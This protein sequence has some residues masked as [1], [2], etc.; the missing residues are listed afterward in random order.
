MNSTMSRPSF[1]GRD[2]GIVD[3]GPYLG[4][5]AQPLLPSTVEEPNR[6]IPRGTRLRDAGTFLAAISVLL[7]SSAL[8]ITMRAERGTVAVAHA[9]VPAKT[10][11][12]A[13]AEEAEDTE[14]AS[15]VHEAPAAEPEVAARPVIAPATPSARREPSSRAAS[16]APRASG[17]VTA[18]TA[19]EPEPEATTR[20]LDQLM[21]GA[22]AP[23]LPITPSRDEVARVL[24][25]LSDEIAQCRPQDMEHTT[26]TTRVT[27][28]GAT[29]GVARATVDGD[30]QWTPAGACI[31]QKL[32][33][34]RFAPFARDRFDVQF[35]YRL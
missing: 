8:V 24:R 4:L 21:D 27:I 19:P 13:P 35:P 2:S 17:G 12:V 32:S 7:S 31:V 30:L 20:T 22:T 11:K 10:A 14:P 34:A 33:T 28:D 3:L 1:P 5:P 18:P 9:R 29:G 26:V 6:R 25:G 23:T 15:T 16:P